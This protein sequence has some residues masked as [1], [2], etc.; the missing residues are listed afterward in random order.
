MITDIRDSITSHNTTYF[1][2][3]DIVAA[4][5]R[6]QW[7]A[8]ISNLVKTR[9]D[10]CTFLVQCLGTVFGYIFIFQKD[11]EAAGAVHL[12]YHCSQC[13]RTA[14]KSCK[15][16]D[17]SKQCQRVT[18][19]CYPCEGRVILMFNNTGDEVYLTLGGQG[20]LLG[21]NGLLVHFYHASFHPPRERKS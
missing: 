1:I 3:E 9:K 16:D 2:I 6:E 8:L 5:S 12:T 10:L 18:E 15:V 17:V 11:R 20:M 19:K 13:R 4:F 7:M 21:K 14:Q